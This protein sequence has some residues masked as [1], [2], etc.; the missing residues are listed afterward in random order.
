MEM[1]T[2]DWSLE[3]T[4]MGCFPEV[5]NKSSFPFIAGTLMNGIVS[6]DIHR[7]VSHI[8]FLRPHMMPLVFI[9][10]FKTFMSF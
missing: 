6:N 8:H 10:F 5:D 2:D 3:D 4:L 1:N 7:C 9:T